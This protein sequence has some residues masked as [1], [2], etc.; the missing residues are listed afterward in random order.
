MHHPHNP[1][2]H[3]AQANLAALRRLAVHASVPDCCR[4][5]AIAWAWSLI[6]VWRDVEE[7]A[8]GVVTTVKV[9]SLGEWYVW[10]LYRAATKAPRS[11]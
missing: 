11:S 5:A 9:R 1:A 4:A 3:T 10:H 8:A 7:D 2:D 6:E